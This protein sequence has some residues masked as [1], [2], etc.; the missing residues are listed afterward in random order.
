MIDILILQKGECKM[1]MNDLIYQ[2][3]DIIQ[4]SYNIIRGYEQAKA[5]TE[6]RFNRENGVSEAAWK[7]AQAKADAEIK[8]IRQAMNTTQDVIKRTKWRDKLCSGIPSSSSIV[9]RA[10]NLDQ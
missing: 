10:P 9:I 1:P 4:H 6:A 3:H 2:Q 8:A 7:S 5:E